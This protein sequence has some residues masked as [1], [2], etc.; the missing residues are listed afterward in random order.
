MV[1]L[2]NTGIL[3]HRLSY[4]FSIRVIKRMHT[5]CQVAFITSYKLYRFRINKSFQQ[6]IS[7]L[8]SSAVLVLLFVSF[9]SFFTMTRL[10]FPSSRSSSDSLSIYGRDPELMDRFEVTSFQSMSVGRTFIVSKY[11]ELMCLSLCFFTL[12]LVISLSGF[13]FNSTSLFQCLFKLNN[14]YDVSNQSVLIF[15]DTL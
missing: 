15:V 4:N 6:R 9:F 12:V 2:S 8:V 13:V 14:D 11:W 5:Q 7:R 1:C 3:Y 10:P